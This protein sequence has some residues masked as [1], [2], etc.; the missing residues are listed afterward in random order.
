MV[1]PGGAIIS[2]QHI[3]GGTAVGMAILHVHMSADIWGDNV[4]EFSPERWLENGDQT[5][6]AKK[7]QESSPSSRSRKD[8]DQWL[9]PFSRGPRMCFGINLAWA[10]LYIA[11]AT[12][13]RRFDLTIDQT[14]DEDME[15]RECI[16]AYYPRRHLHAWCHAA[17]L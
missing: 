13:I 4:L 9:V 5:Y 10:E 2:G 11:F 17:K 16:A 3:P 15:W 14:T 6:A 12:M 7:C 8:L 1:P